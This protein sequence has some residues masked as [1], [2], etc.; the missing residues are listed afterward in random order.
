MIRDLGLVR[1]RAAR[2]QRVATL[3][4]ETEI[5]FASPVQR[6]AFAEELANTLAQLTSKYHSAEGRAFRVIA[7]AY[8]AVQ[9]ER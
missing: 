8:P 4:L 6:T 1:E 2:R 3:A 9:E 5:R 7:G